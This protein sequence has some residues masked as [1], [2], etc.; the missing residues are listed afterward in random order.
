MGGAG[1]GRSAKERVGWLCKADMRDV[2]VM[3]LFRI[4]ISMLVETVY[5]CFARWYHCL[6]G[7]GEFFITSYN[8]M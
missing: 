5:S 1:K 8:C 7:T 3:Q 6:K 2:V 4:N